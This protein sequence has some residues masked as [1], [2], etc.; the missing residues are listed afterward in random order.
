M[1][2]GPVY[3][4]KNTCKRKKR[5]IRSSSLSQSTS[6]CVS[7]G[8]TNANQAMVNLPLTN[9]VLSTVIVILSKCLCH[10]LPYISP[11]SHH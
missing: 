4:I 6:L 1:N 7:K 10:T 3:S 9:N 2:N 8:K 11:F 5:V